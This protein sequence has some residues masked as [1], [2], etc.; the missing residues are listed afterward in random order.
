MSGSGSYIYAMYV[1]AG[2][3]P[4]GCGDTLQEE[5]TADGYLTFCEDASECGWVG[6]SRTRAEEILG[7]TSVTSPE[8]VR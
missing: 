3:C 6:P 8:G 5:M 7:S 4:N 2:L 1:R